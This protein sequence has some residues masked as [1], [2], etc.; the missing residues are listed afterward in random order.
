MPGTGVP[1]TDI[2]DFT[3]FIAAVVARYRGPDQVLRAVETRS[4]G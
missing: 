4:N 3:D 2:K 1:P